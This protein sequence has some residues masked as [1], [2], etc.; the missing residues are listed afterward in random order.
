MS[1]IVS[2]HL[3]LPSCIY[4][5]AI[6]SFLAKHSVTVPVCAFC[7]F[8]KMCDLWWKPTAL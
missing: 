3:I 1:L 4:Q 7:F 5:S 8:N 2:I 6:S